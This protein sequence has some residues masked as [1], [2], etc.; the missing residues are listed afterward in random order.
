MPLLLPAP[1]LS[2]ATG[3]LIVLILVSIFIV[4]SSGSNG[5]SQHGSKE[6]LLYIYDWPG[7]TS[8]FGK[9]RDKNEITTH[10]SNRGAGLAINATMGIYN[11][12]QYQLFSL[13]YHRALM[14]GKRRTLNPLLATSFLIPYDLATDAAYFR[15]NPKDG[16]SKQFDLRKCKQFPEV[17]K[18]LLASEFFLRSGGRDHILIVG[19]NYAMDTY[20]M[21]P[22]CSAM[23]RL[24][25][26]CT[27][28]SIDDYSFLYPN[29]G[30]GDVTAMIKG[31]NW[32][33]V[34]FPA[35]FHWTRHVERPFLWEHT[36][37]S[38]VASYIGSQ[39][40]YWVHARSMRRWLASMCNLNKDCVHRT[41]GKKNREASIGPGQQDPHFRVS[42]ES[43]FCYQPLGDLLTR[44]GLFDALLYGC[45]PV[46]FDPL[47]ASAMY[48][49]HW[50]EK[51]WKQVVVE[52][53][54]SPRSKEDPTAYLKSLLQNNATDVFNRQQLLRHNAFK[55]QYALEGYVP[56]SSWPLDKAGT[57]H[58]D[59]Y[60]IAMDQALGWHSGRLSRR[61]RA[62]VPECWGG[63]TVSPDDNTKCVHTLENK[64]S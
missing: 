59:A 50:P 16:A 11:T 13:M 51:L 22:K 25:G 36:N 33:A 18:L 40:S 27:K 35:N 7:I 24:C 8:S 62:S 12:D 21:K 64:P 42:R 44:K 48:I 61:R 4:G 37:R 57:P 19:M 1:P 38:I 20:I 29:E 63:G 54:Y 26:N 52:M 49:W 34:P 17:E 55:L 60:E 41:Y 14:D 31:R 23:L 32:M 56:N 10:Y 15:V 39:D 47:T 6:E 2:A 53:K 45:I 9:S 28:L 30:E 43:V 58:P 46:T 3:V 5:P